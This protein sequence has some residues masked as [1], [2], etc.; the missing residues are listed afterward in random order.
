VGGWVGGA[1][2]FWDEIKH[3]FSYIELAKNWKQGGCGIGILYV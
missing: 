2:R 3:N 1:P